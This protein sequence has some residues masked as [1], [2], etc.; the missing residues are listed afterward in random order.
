MIPIECVDAR[1]QDRFWSRV[2]GGDFTQ[3]WEWR[4][5]PSRE[6]HYAVFRVTNGAGGLYTAQAHRVAYELLIAPIP[7]GLELDHLCRNRPCVNPWHL[8][9]VTRLVNHRRSLPGR[10]GEPQ[11]SKTHCKHGHQFTPENTY[12]TAG[13]GRQ[14]RLCRQAS[15]AAF[16]ERTG[17]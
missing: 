2:S 1:A 12:F 13:S 16:Y 15:R 10:R 14:C 9:P 6:G 3:C 4:Q 11:R 5:P 8:D 7:E 17:R